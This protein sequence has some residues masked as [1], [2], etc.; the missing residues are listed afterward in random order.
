MEE[1]VTAVYLMVRQDELRPEDN[2]KYDGPLERQKE[3]CIKFLTEKYPDELAKHRVYTGRSALIWDVERDS[4]KRLVVKSVDR[5]GATKED[6]DAL[7]YE[8]THRGVE[9]TEVS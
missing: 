2:G 7:L 4:I 1:K 6:V 5:L 8:L 9:V 3:E